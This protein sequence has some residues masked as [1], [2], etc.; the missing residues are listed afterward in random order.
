LKDTF[1]VKEID[2]RCYMHPT[3]EAQDI[4]S[5]GISKVQELKLTLKEFT[6]WFDDF[7][8]GRLEGEW[9]KPVPPPLVIKTT[10]S[11]DELDIDSLVLE[12]R[13]ISTADL[14]IFMSPPKLSFDSEDD[15][16]KDETVLTVED[17]TTLLATICMERFANLKHKW[18]QTFL[19]VEA[20]Y[21]SVVK[22][23]QHLRT[24]ASGC[25]RLIGYPDATDAGDSTTLWSKIY[26]LGDM[27]QLQTSDVEQI[28]STTTERLMDIQHQQ[29]SFR[30]E[31]QVATIDLETTTRGIEE[32]TQAASN[33]I[34]LLEATVAEYEKH[35]TYILPILMDLKRNG[36]TGTP[37]AAIPNVS[38]LTLAGIQEQLRVLSS[39][40]D[41]VTTGFP[42]LGTLHTPTGFS[43]NDERLQDL[44]NQVR[45]LQQ[46]IVGGSTNWYQDFPI[47]RRC[48]SL[49]G[50][51]T[52]Y[53][54]LWVIC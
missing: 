47:V 38:S 44:E 5:E 52:P 6:A 2:G 41:N 35:F 21:S 1:Y 33:K 51:G 23:L 42:T 9:K 39:K 49:G 17:K 50:C 48:S 45:L 53:S 18:T 27:L 22:D 43:S 10:A 36:P 12:T 40:V 24:Y 28:S 4:S 37:S 20:S 32:S 11:A 25:K 16:L 31:F 29:D 3:F 54:S 26:Q 30:Q 14:G 7:K 15:D 8:E 13:K 46:R 19:E 34:A